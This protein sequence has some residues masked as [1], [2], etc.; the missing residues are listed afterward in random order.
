MIKCLACGFE[1]ERLQWTHFKY[2]CTG[3]FS[4]IKDYLKHYP[5]AL[6]VDP[7]LVK[8]TKITLENFINKYGEIE[9][10]TKWNLY[11]EKQAESNTF[12]YKQ[13]KYGWTKDQFDQYNLSRSQTLENMVERHGEI[14]GSKKWIE[15]CERQ[16]FTNTLEYFIEKYGEIEGI[17]KYQEINIQKSSSVNPLLLSEKLKIS[18]E[19]ALEVI[20]S[21]EKRNGSIWGSLLEQE[22][23]RNLENAL[24]E[25]LEYT[26]FTKPFGKWINEL[27]S[28]VIYDIKHKNCIIEFNGDYWHANPNFYHSNAIIRGKLASE[29]VNRDKIKMQAAENFG[30]R[31]MTVWEFDYKQNKQQTIDKVI[32]WMQNGLQ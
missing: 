29:I 6:V 9:G 20:L 30:F 32:K 1:T 17:L 28:Y 19:S 13:R 4:S 21:R 26:T 18:V 23:T 15:Y 25:K 16:A 10:K 3:K 11:R 31:Q 5:N 2:K 22:F 8:K 7:E 12:E 14:V 27:N 24:N